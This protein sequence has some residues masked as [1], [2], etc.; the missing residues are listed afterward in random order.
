MLTNDYQARIEAAAA[1]AKWAFKA[2]CPNTDWPHIE[3]YPAP[4]TVLGLVATVAQEDWMH[5]SPTVDV[6]LTC[7]LDEPGDPMF[8]EPLALL[9]PAVMSLAEVANEMQQEGTDWAGSEEFLCSWMF[10]VAH[11]TALL[12]HLQYLLIAYA[13]NAKPTEGG[14]R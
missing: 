9:L 12:F 3:H 5:Y 11:A 4:L 13:G 2:V 10:Q 8:S 1:R 7:P 14:D 6:S